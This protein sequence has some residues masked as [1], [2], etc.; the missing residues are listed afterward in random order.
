MT[1]LFTKAHHRDKPERSPL[2]KELVKAT[3]QAK[4][5]LP[6][7][8]KNSKTNAKVPRKLKEHVRRQ[9]E[10]E[11]DVQA[12]VRRIVQDAW[13][14]VSHL[15][16]SEQHIAVIQEAKQLIKRLPKPTSEKVEEY[17][18]SEIWEPLLSRNSQ[19]EPLPQN[20]P[21]PTNPPRGVPTNSVAQPDMDPFRR[22]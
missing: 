1:G 6:K 22:G 14:A 19:P 16:P 4:L 8:L 5:A 21:P 11:D 17:F 10:A 12:A 15:L 9:V 2:W 7:Q 18:S 20:P 13:I 3:V